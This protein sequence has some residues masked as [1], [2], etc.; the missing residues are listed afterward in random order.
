MA[1]MIFQRLFYELFS[2]LFL[3][4]LPFY[5]YKYNPCRDTQCG[6]RQ[7]GNTHNNAEVEKL[8]VFRLHSQTVE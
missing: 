8:R 7:H 5:N 2:V 4:L 6:K 1:L 3:I